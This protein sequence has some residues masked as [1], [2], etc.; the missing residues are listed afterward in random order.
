MHSNYPPSNQTNPTLTPINP[1][2]TPIF[3]LTTLEQTQP[4]Q[5][6]F[7]C[8]LFKQQ[9]LS[10]S[11]QPPLLSSSFAKV[12]FCHF[13]LSLSFNFQLLLLCCVLLVTAK[14]KK[15]CF[16]FRSEVFQIW[17]LRFWVGF[18]CFFFNWVGLGFPNRALTECV[19]GNCVAVICSKNLILHFDL[20]VSLVV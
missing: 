11:H 15:S 3:A 8:V 12:L 13:F 9:P 16:F 5:S 19:C 20:I 14:K 10:F 1:H 6:G 2:I 4:R 7:L 18:F 17:I